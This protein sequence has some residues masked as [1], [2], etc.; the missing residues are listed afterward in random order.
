MKAELRQQAIRWNLLRFAF[1]QLYREWKSGQLWVLTLALVTAIASHTA[2][3]HFSDRIG[4]A[5]ASNA[6]NLIAGDLIV[7]SY[8]PFEPTLSEKALAIGAN[9]AEKRNLTTMSSA[10]D[11]F[12]LANITAVSPNYPLK[13]DIQIADALYADAYAVKHPPSQDGAWVDARI[14]TQLDLAIGDTLRLGNKDFTVTK[15]LIQ[16]LDSSGGFYN[17]TP[18]ILINLNDL[19]STG[20]A[21]PG[22]RVQHQLM[23]TG[24]TRQ[25]ESLRTA[26]TPLL[27]SG[28]RLRSIDEERPGI[29]QALDRANQYTGLASLV[30]LLLAAVAVA[31]SG[32]HYIQRHFDTSALMRCIGASQAF[33]V[34]TFVIQLLAIACLCG[35]LG[36]LLGWSIQQGLIWMIRDLLPN[37]IPASRFNTV[38]SGM[39]LSFI[40]LLGFTLPSLIRLKNVSPSK[41][42][43]NDL[44]PLPLSSWL[45]YAGAVVLIVGLMWLYTGNLTLTLSVTIGAAIVLGVSI[46]MIRLLYQLL[47]RLLPYFPNVMRPGMRHFLRRNW[48]TSAQT[49]AFGLTIMA[50]MLIFSIRTNLINTWQTSVP[51]DAP[52]HFVINLQKDD[53]AAYIE[54]LHKLAI[55]ETPAFPVVRGRLTQINAQPVNEVVSQENQDHESIRRELNLTWATELPADNR[56]TQGSWWHKDE[57]QPLVSVEADIAKDLNIRIGDQLTFVTGAKTWQAQVS[58]LRE[59]DWG[60]FKPNFYMIFTPATLDG[61]PSTWL[62]SFYLPKTEKHQLVDLVRLFPAV[63]VIELDIVLAQ[64]RHIINQVTLVLQALL[65]FVLLAAFSVTL[66]ELKSSLSQRIREG[67]IIRTLGAGSHQIRLAQWTEFAAIGVFSG[68]VGMLGTDIIN[69]LIY[70]RLFDITYESSL[71]MWITVITLSALIIGLLGVYNSR[72]V[73]RNS[74]ITS[75][76]DN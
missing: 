72:E 30:A 49:I 13:G 19:G 2:I 45:T 63:S 48:T 23:F 28:E 40:M 7:S 52:N 53:K 75:L 5:I 39:L 20:I 25:I 34:S 32:R 17:L 37:D 60:N 47:G 50:L 42:L 44:L 3:G 54:F 10:N 55:K 4:R 65:L 18:R 11:A 51:L 46:L 66:S 6:N 59:V 41:V 67:A 15:V 69:R 76:R 24:D 58:S 36:N 9:V 71:L 31:G 12:L 61:L 38:I 1:K 14:L 68:M 16:T 35:L 21:Q 29:A 64:A 62:H 26:L 74:P 22:S 70:K 57:A 73:I 33:T 56:I 8:R 43:R 27:K